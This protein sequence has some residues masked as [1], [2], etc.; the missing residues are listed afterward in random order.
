MTAI[1]G[2]V[3]GKTVLMFDDMIT[4]G[5]TVAEAAK[6][7]KDQGAGDDTRGGDARDFRGPG[8]GETQRRTH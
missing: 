3:K 1:I 5:G 2:D 7:L 8:G 6:I 4:T